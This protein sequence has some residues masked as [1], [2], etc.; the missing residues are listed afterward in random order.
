MI[1]IKLPKPKGQ[2]T[3]TTCKL[4]EKGQKSLNELTEKQGITHKN[5]FTLILDHT[6]FIESVLQ[7]IS[8]NTTLSKGNIRKS[9]VIGKNNLDRLNEISKK[10]GIARD[11]IIDVGVRLLRDIIQKQNELTLINHAKSLTKLRALYDQ[12][13]SVDDDLRSFLDDDDPVV[14]RFSEACVILMN[15]ILS[16]ENERDNGT[17]ISP[18][19]A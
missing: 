9:F 14:E 8:G 11:T 19:R 5:I 18:E 15:L 3:R 6:D 4:T 1:K 10:S 13:E 2:E 12:V 7:H 16:L 17:S